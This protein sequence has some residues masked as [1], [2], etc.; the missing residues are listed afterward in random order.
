M[1]DRILRKPE[2]IKTVGLKQTALYE[3]ISDGEFPR[4]IQL[5][6]RSVGWLESEVQQWIKD[7]AEKRRQ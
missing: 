3:L 4:P 6:K 2:V 5:S 1:G 7:Q